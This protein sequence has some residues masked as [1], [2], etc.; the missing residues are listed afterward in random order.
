MRFWRSKGTGTNAAASPGAK[1]LGWQRFLSRFGDTG[2]KS[3]RRGHYAQLQPIP[4]AFAGLIILG[5][6]LLLLP[7]THNRGETISWLDA[8]FL[9]T[10]ATCV[11]GLSTV[12]VAEVFNGFGQFVLLCLIQA[13][14]IG[15]MTAGTFFLVLTGNRLSLSHEQ[16]IAG[17][18]GQLR[19]VRPGDIF[20]YACVVVLLAELAGA[21]ALFGMITTEWP[22]QPVGVAVWQ[23]VFHSVSAFCNAG[24]S[25]F[26]DGISHWRNTPGLL[27]VVDALVITGGIGLLTL[28]NLRYCYWWRRDSRKRGNIS[29]QTKISLLLTVLLLG[30]GTLVTMVLEWNGTL[31]EAGSFWERLSWSFFHSTMTR[32]AGFNV[33]DM[34]AMHPATLQ[35]SMVLMFIGGAPGSMA[36]GIKTSTTAVLFLAAWVA[37]R[38]RPEVNLF[39]R[40]VSHNQTAAAVMIL[41]MAVATL[42]VGVILLMVTEADGPALK[43]DYGWLGIVFEAVSAFGTVGLSADVTPLLT[44]PGKAIIIALM[45]VGRVGPLMLAMHLC[46]PPISWHVR[47]PEESI[48]LG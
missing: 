48:S 5:A 24:I 41:L 33:V 17:A 18:F 38:R 15:I 1:P 44:E 34:G 42:L 16:S 6:V 43:N 36:G 40:R 39:H 29:L 10:S 11:T 46:R 26:P 35:M 20:A 32:T 21:V 9:S 45:F 28:V 23:A 30:I 3:T 25:I 7:F 14:G 27:G 8:L 22:D 13:G 47:Y 4:Y 37:L 2:F 12:N 31:S 19:S